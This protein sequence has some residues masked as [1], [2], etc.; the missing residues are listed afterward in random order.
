MALVL[1]LVVTAVLP[2]CRKPEEPR[3]RTVRFTV[4]GHEVTA[5]LA[6]TPETRQK[7]LM[8]RRSLAPDHGMLF[9]H[10]APQR[11]SF[12]MKNTRIPLSIAFIRVAG[13]E[14]RTGVILHIARMKPLSVQSYESPAPVRYALEMECSW[15]EK[16]GVKAGDRVEFPPGIGQMR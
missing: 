15:F 7:G 5:E 4:G 16:H 14:S 3:L 6:A 10:P 1:A 13:G 2:S 8:G 9:V 11:L 12:W